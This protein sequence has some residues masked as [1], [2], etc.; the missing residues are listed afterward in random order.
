MRSMRERNALIGGILF[1]LYLLL[2]IGFVLLNAFSPETME[3]MPL[4]GINLALIY[5][6]GLIATACVFAFLYGLLCGSTESEKS[7]GET[8]K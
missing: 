6:F 7:A 5:G 1:V 8:E 4:D 2:Y 3:L